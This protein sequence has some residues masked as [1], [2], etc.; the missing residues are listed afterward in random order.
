M[1]AAK[2]GKVTVGLDLGASLGWALVRGKHL[3][4]CGVH[5]LKDKS[6]ANRCSTMANFMQVL[7]DGKPTHVGVEQPPYVQRVYTRADGTEGKGG[8]LR[9]YGILNQ[10]LGVASAAFAGVEIQITNINVMTLKKWATGNGH[11]SK[12]RVQLA[13][14]QL[15]GSPRLLTLPNDV[16]DAVA[17][18]YYVNA[19]TN[20]DYWSY[21]KDWRM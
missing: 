6:M 18:A 8:N 20:P 2:R 3:L 14:T 1:D 16:A 17:C 13:M 12:E 19:L 5:K 7:I 11:A 21:V 10:Y 15:S 4:D 9:T